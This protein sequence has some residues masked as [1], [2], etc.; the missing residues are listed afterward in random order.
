MTRVATTIVKG[1]GRN[2]FITNHSKLPSNSWSLTKRTTRVLR[3]PRTK[4]ST[5]TASSRN[6]S[7]R[8]EVRDRSLCRLWWTG[9]SQKMIS[10]VLSYVNLNLRL[11]VDWSIMSALIEA[12]WVHWLKRAL[13]LMINSLEAKARSNWNRLRPMRTSRRIRGYKTSTRTWSN[14]YLTRCCIFGCFMIG[15]NYV[16]V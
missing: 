4:I 13:I 7:A 1:G 2:L 3:V 15:S 6:L 11:C 8:E 5:R 12:W 9:R 10:L 16:H 14:E